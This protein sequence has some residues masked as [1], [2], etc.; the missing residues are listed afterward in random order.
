VQ[1]I[2]STKDLNWYAEELFARFAILSEHG[3]L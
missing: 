1:A 3:V 2:Q